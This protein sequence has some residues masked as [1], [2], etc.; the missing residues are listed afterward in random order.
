MALDGIRNDFKLV[1]KWIQ[2][3]IKFI[4]VEGSIPS[5]AFFFV[6]EW[7]DIPALIP[8]LPGSEGRSMETSRST[9]LSCMTIVI[10]IIDNPRQIVMHRAHFDVQLNRGNS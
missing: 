8:A 2:N 4:Q 7:F 6:K 1:L 9:E 3:G 10:T 5:V